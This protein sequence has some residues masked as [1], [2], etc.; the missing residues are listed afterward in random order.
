MAAVPARALYVNPG[1]FSPPVTEAQS[2]LEPGSWALSIASLDGSH[3]P[4]LAASR[5]RFG[6]NGVR[7]NLHRLYLKLAGGHHLDHAASGAGLH[8]G[9]LLQLLLHLVQALPAS[10][11]PAWQQVLVHP[12]HH[13]AGSSWNSKVSPSCSSAVFDFDSCSRYD[14][15]C[16]RWPFD[17]HVADPGPGP[18]SISLPQLSSRGTGPTVLPSTASMPLAHRPAAFGRLQLALPAA[19]CWSGCLN[20]PAPGTPSSMYGGDRLSRMR[21]RSNVEKLPPLL[22]LHGLLDC[23]PVLLRHGAAGH[24]WGGLPVF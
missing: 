14:R 10:A 15:P 9:G 5:R 23:P 1:M 4:G 24:D 16:T 6:I 12:L 3:G 19:P 17:Y 11:G 22:P 8:N 7:S 21:Q 13:G 18:L 2:G 20:R